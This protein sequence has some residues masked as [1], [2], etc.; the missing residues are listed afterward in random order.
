MAFF[1]LVREER[2]NS[3]SLRTK[4]QN[5]NKNKHPTPSSSNFAGAQEA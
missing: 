5:R 2:W 1:Q 4:A 3:P